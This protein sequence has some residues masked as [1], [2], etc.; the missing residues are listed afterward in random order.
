[1]GN[2]NSNSVANSGDFADLTGF[3]RTLILSRHNSG[4]GVQGKTEFPA[5]W[6]DNEIIHHI[7]DV[8]TDPSSITGIG[9]YNSPYANGKSH[10]INIRV[11]FYPIGH[12]KYDNQISTGY[13]TNVPPNK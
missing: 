4:A 12:Y 11:D 9:K 3:R 6:S 2:S 10:G 13:P 8:A 5:S 1:M 7:S